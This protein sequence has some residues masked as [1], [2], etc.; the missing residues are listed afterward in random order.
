M[1]FIQKKKVEKDKT[2]STAGEPKDSPHGGHDHHDHSD[3][4][5]ERIT[6][7]RGGPLWHIHKNPDGSIS[8]MH[9]VENS[10]STP[11]DKYMDDLLAR[12]IARH[13]ND[14]DDIDT[15]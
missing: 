7:G 8:H 4:K 13:A 11:T 1:S 10:G 3:R 15:K 2:E 12:V 9:E 14:E 5:G 6:T